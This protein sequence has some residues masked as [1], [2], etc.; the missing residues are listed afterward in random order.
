MTV[1]RFNKIY[2]TYLNTHYRGRILLGLLC[3]KPSE[4]MRK[5][6]Q[7]TTMSARATSRRGSMGD[8]P[9]RSQGGGDARPRSER[10]P[11]V[12]FLKGSCSR[13]TKCRF[14]HIQTL[15]NNADRR[16]F[17]FN[18]TSTRQQDQLPGNRRQGGRP[19]VNRQQRNVQARHRRQPLICLTGQPYCS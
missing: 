19:L 9:A 14:R 18:R 2:L 11:C 15:N 10:E 12:Y 5:G 16:V 8:A 4:A 3:V 13:G 6:I 1:W 7:D 17:T